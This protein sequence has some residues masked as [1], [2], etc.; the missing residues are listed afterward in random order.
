MYIWQRGDWPEFR[1]RADAL[2][3]LLAG[4]RHRQGRLLG[5]MEALGFRSKQEAVLRTLTA[6]VV[7]SSE[8]EGERLDLDQVRSSI[9]R[10]LGVDIGALT[11]A[12]RNVEG[13]VEMMLDATGRYDQP[14]TGARLS[15]WH[16]ALFPT[17]R[18]GVTRIQVGA[19]R[20]DR[21]GPMEVVSGPMGKERV[22]FEAPPAERV[23]SE[24]T[25]FL[26][27]CEAG[28]ALDGV[29][30]AGL[31]HLWLVTVHPF[32]D[33]NGRIAR[34]VADLMLARSEETG[35]RYYSMSA[36]IRQERGAYYDI[37]EE[38]QHGTLD[39]TRWLRWFLETLD[40]A[41]AR[42]HGTLGSVLQQARFWDSVTQTALNDRQRLVLR[43]MLGGFEGKLTT[44]KYAKLAKC[45]HDT[46]LRDIAALVEQ[47]ALVR[48]PEGGRSTGYA[49]AEVSSEPPDGGLRSAAPGFSGYRD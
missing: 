40:G 16:A 49:L 2:A 38:T 33:G 39:V 6:D 13:V 42:A 46:A 11:P 20:D 36:Q 29:L 25:R 12:D 1:W 28:P 43:K 19:W 22:H 45:S 9:A 35:Q 44:S 27:W 26:E 17:G 37:L 8:I 24:M 3:D 48:G 4:V 18:S 10:R 15:D 21:T 34:A 47:C 14:L 30:K 5:R 7:K 32:D 41:I 23:D 31:A